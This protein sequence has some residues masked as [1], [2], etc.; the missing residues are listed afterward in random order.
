MDTRVRTERAADG[1]EPLTPAPLPDGASARGSARARRGRR[2]GNGVAGAILAAVLLVAA[3]AWWM[4]RGTA[5][6]RYLTVPV[7][8]G[9]I[10]RTVSATGTVNPVMTIIVGSYVSGVVRDVYCDYNT[11][12]RKGQICARIDPRP[13]QAALAQA[14]GQLARDTAQL[15]GA[16][17]DLA[18]YG[19][20]IKE[21]L[22]AR[23]TYTDQAALVQQL[24]GQT[25]LDRASVRNAE[26][27]L[28]YTDIVSPVDGTVVARNIT[29]GQTVAASFQTPTLFLI[30]TDLTRMQVDTNV[31][32]S[33]IGALEDGDPASF[34]VEAFPGRTFQGSVV[35]VRQAPQVVQN[36]VTYDA[37]VGVANSDF[38]LKPGMTATVG[39]VTERRA[40]VVRVADQALRF[41]P[42][43]FTAAATARA[44]PGNGAPGPAPRPAA[45]GEPQRVWVL[46]AGK[47]VAVPVRTGLDDGTYTE[48][49]G[50][51]L[52]PGDP[53]IV[54]EQRPED[55][56]RAR[57]FRFGL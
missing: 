33:D 8:R 12:V 32:E 52:R 30:A 5:P 7:T 24:E 34:T 40:N 44:P 29:I 15:S 26:V 20:L 39:I 11:K 47:P 41:V 21:N 23:M 53:V 19:A 46:R 35:Q 48:I 18:R 56:P 51:A 28:G 4:T 6:P 25:E 36:V 2:L 42:G 43:G 57:A 31:S 37:V 1:R 55:S 49:E 14:R 16:R 17:A 10:A 54:G 3:A 22:V 45:A 9:A 27:N 38:R 13:Y 50:G